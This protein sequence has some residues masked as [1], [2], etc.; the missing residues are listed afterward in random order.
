MHEAICVL[1]KEHKTGNINAFH[2]FFLLNFCL[3][4][5]IKSDVADW[6]V[7]GAFAS[8]STHLAILLHVDLRLQF[9]YMPGTSRSISAKDHMGDGSVGLMPPSEDRFCRSTKVCVWTLKSIKQKSH[10][11]VG[12]SLQA[13]RQILQILKRGRRDAQDACPARQQTACYSSASSQWSWS[14]VKLI[15]WHIDTEDHHKDLSS[16]AGIS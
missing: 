6:H 1:Q 13:F 2:A 3:F 12:S 15:Y 16:N 10:R 8:Q 5:Y 14:S 11:A 7:K 4:I 9:T